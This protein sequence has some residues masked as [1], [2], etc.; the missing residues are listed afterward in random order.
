MRE[1]RVKFVRLFSALLGTAAVASSAV[2]QTQEV[3]SVAYCH[4]QGQSFAEEAECAC[5]NAL[6]ENTIEALENYIMRYGNANNAC[7]A[8]AQAALAQFR[9][10]GS[11]SDHPGP[12]D[13]GPY[14][15]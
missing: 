2:A 10:N 9:P 15:G 1:Y 12:P 8:L 11:N 14:G 5:E 7:M 13:R 4:S 3:A 6:R